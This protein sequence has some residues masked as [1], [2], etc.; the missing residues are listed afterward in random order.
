MSS[1]ALPL[2]VATDAS[3][4]GVLR[5]IQLHQ[6]LSILSVPAICVQLALLLVPELKLPSP[7][8]MCFEGL[9]IFMRMNQHLGSFA[10]ATGR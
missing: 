10:I 2:R 4:R 9:L 7:L 1:F 6:R 3:G 8:C 5:L